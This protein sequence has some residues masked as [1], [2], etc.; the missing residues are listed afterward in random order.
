MCA[1]A[2]CYCTI[3]NEYLALTSFGD[4]CVPACHCFCGYTLT[5]SPPHTLPYYPRTQHPPSPLFQAPTSGGGLLPQSWA[6]GGETYDWRP[7]APTLFVFMLT[8]T[9]TMRF[10]DLTPG[11]APS[12]HP[13]MQPH[14]TPTSSPPTHLYPIAIS[15]LAINSLS[16]ACCWASPQQPLRIERPPTSTQATPLTPANTQPPH[17]LAK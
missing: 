10:Q 17:P 8:T 13:C 1:Y 14:F 4:V 2:Y 7:A 3:Y 16:R 11:L 5:I 9:A 15:V 6:H 12:Q